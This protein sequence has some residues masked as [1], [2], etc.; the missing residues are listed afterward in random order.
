M[1]KIF[2]HRSG[3]SSDILSDISSAECFD[4]LSGTFSHISSGILSDIS[5]DILSG[6][7]SDISSDT[8]VRSF[9]ATYI[10]IVNLFHGVGYLRFL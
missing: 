6:P 4:I 2:R 8:Q 3:K 7:F 1:V 5:S 9:S 10:E